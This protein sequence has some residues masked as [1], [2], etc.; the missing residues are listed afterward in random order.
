MK[1]LTHLMGKLTQAVS[2]RDNSRDPEFQTPLMKESDSFYITKAYELR[3]F[4]QSCKLMF[5]NDPESFF[6]D[7]K[8]VL[9]SNSCLTG[10]AG[11]L[12]EPFLSNISDEAPSNLLSYW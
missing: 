5:H 12:I 10:S 8:K 2:T 9:F 7:R 1:E 6:S 4:I 3:V 11:K